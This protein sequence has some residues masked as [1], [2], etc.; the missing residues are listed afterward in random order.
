VTRVL[1]HAPVVCAL[2]CALLLPLAAQ[3]AMLQQAKVTVGDGSSGDRF[4]GQSAISGDTAVIGAYLDDPK[5][6]DSG[7]AYVFT[8][9]GT[10]WT[11]QA[12][13]TPADGQAGDRFAERVGIAGDTIV[14]GAPWDDDAGADAGSAYV[15][16][17]VGATWSQQAKLTAGDAAAA[18]HFGHH[19]AIS[20]NTIVIGAP[21]DDNPSSDAGSVYVFTRSGTTWTQQAKL[22]A[23]D[24]AANDVFGAWTGISGDT[25]VVGAP[26]DDD[27]GSGSGSIYVFTRAGT[28]W[29]LQSKITPA[30]GQAGDSFGESVAI[31]ADTIL[32]GAYSDD[33]LAADAGSAYVFTRTGTTWTQQAKLLA[34][35]G[36]TGD[37]FG[38]STALD[39]NLAVVG[40]SNDTPNGASSGSA[41]VFTRAGTVW[42]EQSKLTASDGAPLDSFA[43]SMA[44]SGYTAVIGAS[45]NDAVAT[46]AGA[47]YIFRDAVAA[48][49]LVGGVGAGRIAER[50]EAAVAA[51]SG[52]PGGWWLLAFTAAAAL[53]LGAVIVRQSYRR[54]S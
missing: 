39:G 22:S 14:A 5:G 51:R 49:D 1:R 23:S 42:S 27:N 11:Q 34:S 36:T 26:G 10:T 31:S 37:S 19:A 41:Y 15:F 16:T 38:I 29:T 53:A 4:G 46:D 21:N 20:G 45:G 40:A 25:V 52:M 9:S 35:D 48:G 13:L 43:T 12:K 28:T 54:R 7:A 18:D 8:R 3:A 47:A 17:R 50:D 33:D 24:A 44:V 32:V 6:T 30:D 2:I